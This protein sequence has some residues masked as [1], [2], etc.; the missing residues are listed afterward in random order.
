MARNPPSLRTAIPSR[1]SEMGTKSCVDLLFFVVEA[2]GID[3]VRGS[4]FEV[5]DECSISLLYYVFFSHL[6]PHRSN[7]L[8]HRVAHSNYRRYDPARSLQTL[9]ALDAG[10]N[11]LFDVERPRKLMKFAIGEF[12]NVN[13]TFLLLRRRFSGRDITFAL[14]IP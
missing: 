4:R 1:T 13:F 9:V 3:Q 5:R 2:E 6:A 10:S 8:M 7:L 14:V 12:W 11:A